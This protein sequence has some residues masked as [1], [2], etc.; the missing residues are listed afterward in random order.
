V[1][2]SSIVTVFIL[3]PNYFFDGDHVSLGD[4]REKSV[5]KFWPLISFMSIEPPN[6]HAD[7]FDVR[8]ELN[9]AKAN[10]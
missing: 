9:L 10:A 6:I 3:N 4:P 8:L 7:R 1:T 5:T 2:L